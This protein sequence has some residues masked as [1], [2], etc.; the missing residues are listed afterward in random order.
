M[1]IRRSKTE[2]EGQGQVIAV[3]RGAKLRPVELLQLWL[4]RA[5]ISAGLVFRPV[6]LGGKVSAEP[7]STDAIARVVKKHARRLGLDPKAFG[8]LSL[9][10]AASISPPPMLPVSLEPKTKHE[11][12]G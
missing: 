7:L 3:P 1:L 8:G 11:C 2:Q 10:S 6:A 12:Q 4:A 5:E 9:R